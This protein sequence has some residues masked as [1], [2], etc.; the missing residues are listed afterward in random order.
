MPS[1]GDSSPREAHAACSRDAS[2]TTTFVSA[3]R[4][5]AD[6]TPRGRGPGLGRNPITW[7]HAKG[8]RQIIQAQ[9]NFDPVKTILCLD[10]AALGPHNKKLNQP[11]QLAPGNERRVTSKG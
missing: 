2:P 6:G 11:P 8:I 5:G 9:E 3:P 4:D 1:R 7:T 10:S